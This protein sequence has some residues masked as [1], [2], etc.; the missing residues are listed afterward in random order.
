[1][2]EPRDERPHEGPVFHGNSSQN[3]FAWGNET[4]TQNQ[5]I[6]T[7]VAEGYEPLAARVAELL[8]RLPEQGLPDQDREDAEAA[9][10][11][12]LTTLTRSDPPE[13]TRLRRALATLRG[14]L[15]PV[16]M[17]AAAGTTVATQEWARA[18]IE[19]LIA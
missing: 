7:K 6:N 18:A 17:G 5:Q 13:E 11:E 2:S 19:S 4:V 12:V 3:L 8:R 10:G 1:M 14:A 16:A 15:T 9:A